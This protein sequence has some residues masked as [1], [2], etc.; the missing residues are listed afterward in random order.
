MLSSKNQ[1]PTFPVN[2]LW[3]DPHEVYKPLNSGA[4]LSPVIPGTGASP[5]LRDAPPASQINI[6]KGLVP[7]RPHLNATPRLGGLIAKQTQKNWA[8]SYLR[9]IF[10]YFFINKYK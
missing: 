6:P 3:D 9:S 8:F 1:D 4:G 2:Q 5:Q 7:V 10:F